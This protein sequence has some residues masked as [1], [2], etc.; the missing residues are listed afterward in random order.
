MRNFRQP[1]AA[2]LLTAVVAAPIVITGCAARVSTGYTVHDN[3]YND[4]HVW[5]NNEV[6]YYN[7]WESDTHRDHKDFRKRPANEQKEYWTWR[8][9]PSNNDHH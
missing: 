2:L 5:D 7:R 3:Y 6:A 9:S 4:D 1:F 8:H